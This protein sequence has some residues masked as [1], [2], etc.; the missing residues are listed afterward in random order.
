[1]KKNLLTLHPKKFKP[2]YQTITVQIPGVK[3]STRLV[4]DIASTLTVPKS[5]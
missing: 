2:I 1:M 5:N 3:V 4:N